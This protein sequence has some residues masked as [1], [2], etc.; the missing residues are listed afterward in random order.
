L[1]KLA[2]LSLYECPGDKEQ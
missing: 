1:D 2:R